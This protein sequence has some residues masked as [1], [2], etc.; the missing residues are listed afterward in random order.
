MGHGHGH[1]SDNDRHRLGAALGVTLFTAVLGA[2]GAALTGSL[3]LLAD[4]G[5]LLTDAG[6]LL[7]AF[8]ATVLAARPRTARRTYGFSRVEVLVA[9]LN[10]LA[11]LAV[12]AW[13]AVEAVQRLSDPADVPGVPMLVVGVLGLLGNIVSLLI[14]GGG[15][16]QNM[17]MRGAAMH[18][19][20]DALGSVG[21]L[22]AAI[23]LITTGWPYADT[24]ASLAIVALIVPRAVRLVREAWHILLEGAP[25]SVD[26][27]AVRRSL[28]T[29]P[30]V[31][32]VHDL[33]VW[34]INDRTPA[35]S[36]HLVL[37]GGDDA[38]PDH[39]RV[40]DVAAEALREQFGLTHTT[41]QIEPVTHA[42]HETICP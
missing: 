39:G 4:L 19:L 42:G 10:A 33:H 9:G 35:A 40:L 27:D 23:V 1:S 34:T 18:V 41:L 14:L 15:D 12:V 25:D 26:V 3:A 16:R 7:A 20:G 8:V 11:L 6:A 36:A 31:A 2:V 13:I 24:V 17:N 32:D 21:V 37:S 22:A 28:L 5:H 38:A 30:G 29:V